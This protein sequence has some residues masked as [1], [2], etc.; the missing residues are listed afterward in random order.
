MFLPM[1]LV[2]DE[3][4]KSLCRSRFQLDQVMYI[5]EGVSRYVETAVGSAE[6]IQ[7]LVCAQIETCL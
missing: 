3:W 1:S 7:L 6:G 5:P 2:P 4:W